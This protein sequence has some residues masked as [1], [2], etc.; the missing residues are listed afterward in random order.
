MHNHN[1]T[2]RSEMTILRCEEENQNYKRTVAELEAILRKT[3]SNGELCFDRKSGILKFIIKLENT[4]MK[5]VTH[6][7]SIIND[8]DQHIA[9]AARVFWEFDANKGVLYVGRDKKWLK[10]E[11]SHNKDKLFLLMSGLS[12][13]EYQRLKKSSVPPVPQAARASA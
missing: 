12:L 3:N 5:E 11:D 2:V 10:V 7:D 13:E 9:A 1:Y 8:L 6:L 4:S